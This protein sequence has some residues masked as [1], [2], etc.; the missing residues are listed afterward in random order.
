MNVTKMI[1]LRDVLVKLDRLHA[2][3]HFTMSVFY[4]TI[5]EDFDGN[6][7]FYEPSMT[8]DAL[9]QAITTVKTTELDDPFKCPA[10]CC[11]AGWACAIN[12]GEFPLEKKWVPEVDARDILEL[13]ADE[14]SHMFYGKWHPDMHWS[15]EFDLDDITLEDAIK[16]LDAV[17]EDHDVF[18]SDWYER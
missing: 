1:E 18:V 4:G 3:D 16:Y 12:S 17:I 6:K 8:T 11:L 9:H 15:S 13:D 7:Y 10:A 5:E 14:A 2:G